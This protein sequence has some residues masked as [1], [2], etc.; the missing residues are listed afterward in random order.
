M[1]VLML[2]LVVKEH[3]TLATKAL[4]KSTPQLISHQRKTMVVM[5]VLAIST[6][7]LENWMALVENLL[8]KLVLMTVLVP[9]QQLL[10]KVVK[11]LTLAVTYL[12]RVER[13]LPKVVKLLP[14]V[15][16]LLPKVVKL[17]LNRPKVETIMTRLAT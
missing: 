10:S 12:L 6:W 15:V 11:E 4:R 9:N 3:L 8:Q 14:K 2:A 5:Q 16:K 7:V 17:L 1:L 13:L